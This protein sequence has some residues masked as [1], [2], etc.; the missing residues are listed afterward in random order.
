LL[1]VQRAFARLTLPPSAGKPPYWATN[2]Q[3]SAM[4]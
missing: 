2:N 3:N 1:S 4:E